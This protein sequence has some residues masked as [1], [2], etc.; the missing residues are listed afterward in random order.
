MRLLLAQWGGGGDSPIVF[1]LLWAFALHG[2]KTAPEGLVS[3]CWGWS[4]VCVIKCQQDQ[5]ER[6]VSQPG[7]K[8]KHPRHGRSRFKSLKEIV[9]IQFP[10]QGRQ[11]R[12][13]AEKAYFRVTVDWVWG[14]SL[15][16]RDAQL[17]QT[18]PHP[19]QGCNPALLRLRVIPPRQ[20]LLF[21]K[22]EQSRGKLWEGKAIFPP[23]LLIKIWVQP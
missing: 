20:P 15:G 3:L 23:P 4:G 17:K 2:F 22:Q 6:F 21:C 19:I 7:D 14:C 18:H 11:N 13:R 8:N 9:I 1:L 10:V 5:T 12:M 16:T